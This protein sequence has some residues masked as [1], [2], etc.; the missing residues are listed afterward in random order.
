M[1]IVIADDT[2]IVRAGLRHLL[3]PTE[4]E[5]VGEAA[6]GTEL[7]RLV[8][9]ARPDAAIVD[10]R[11]PPTRTDEGIVAARI[12]RDRH[13]DTAVLVL[14]EYLQPRYADRLLANRPAGLGYLLKERV[15]DLTTLVDALERIH[16]G[17]CVVDPTIIERLMAMRANSPLKDLTSRE[18]QVLTLLAEGRSNAA[19]ATR[20]GI[21]ERSVESLCAA[22]FR[23]LG[24]EPDPD[25]NRRVLAVLTLLRPPRPGSSAPPR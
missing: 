14:S 9:T 16:A 12:I 5:I 8:A 25:V 15:A 24:L 11:M 3:A 22:L 10:I 23:K 2:L 6:D 17:E 4:V 7:L 20:L 1:R 18:R 19:V 21:A 13:P